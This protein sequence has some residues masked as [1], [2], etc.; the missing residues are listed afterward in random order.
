MRRAFL[1]FCILSAMS[2][3]VSAAPPEFVEAF[4]T[5][6]II[7]GEP[8]QTFI[9][10]SD[11]DPED[12][13]LIYMEPPPDDPGFKGYLTFEKFADTSWSFQ[14]TTFYDLI[15]GTDSIFAIRFY[16][17]DYTD[18][19]FTDASIT[20]INNNPRPSIVTFGDK[21]IVEGVTFID[22]VSATDPDGSIPTLS[23]STLPANSDF[24]LDTLVDTALGIF[25]FT[26]DNTQYGD[27]A[28][29]Y[30]IT[31]NASDEDS[32]AANQVTITVTGPNEAPTI[33]ELGPQTITEG[34]LLSLPILAIDPNE[35]RLELY[36][37]EISQWPQMTFVDS[38]AVSD[39]KWGVGVLEFT[40][41][42]LWSDSSSITVTIF[43][44]DGAFVA[45]QEVSITVDDA[46][47]QDPVFDPFPDTTFEEGGGTLEITV[48]ASDPEQNRLSLLML[49][50]L[51]NSSFTIDT[52]V[53]QG[54]VGLYSF[55]PGFDQGGSYEIDFVAIDDSLASD[56]ITL[57]LEIV[58]VDGPP[59]LFVRP[60]GAQSINEGQRLRIEWEAYDDFETGLEV[61]IFP[62]PDSSIF[63]GSLANIDLTPEAGVNDSGYM[64]FAPD[65]NFLQGSNSA[66]F[67]IEFSASDAY[68]TVTQSK[69]ITVYDVAQDD[70]DPGEADTVNLVNAVWDDSIPGFKFVSR[71]WNDSAVAA[72]MTGYRWFDS[73]FQCEKIEF[74]DYIL[75]SAAYTRT[76]IYND[77]LTFLATFIF[78]DSL[79]LPPGT[80]DH[81]TAY[82]KYYPDPE[83][84]SDIFPFLYDTASVGSNG[85]YFFDK[86]IR[87]KSQD[88][89]TEKDLLFAEKSPYTYKPLIKFGEVR[90]PGNRVRMEIYDL[91]RKVSLGRGDMLFARD[92]AD[93]QKQYE[94]RLK[95]ENETRLENISLDLQVFTES[96]TISWNYSDP[97]AEVIPSSRMAPDNQVWPVT[98]GLQL[99]GTG[100]DGLG[101]DS[102]RLTGAA[103]SGNGGLPR[104]LLEYMIKIPFTMNEVLDDS[105]RVY[106][107]RGGS[108]APGTWLFTDSSG[109]VIEPLFD[110]GLDLGV[111][112][113]SEI[114]TDRVKISIFDRDENEAIEEGDTLYARYS[115]FSL[116]HY[117]LRL[118]IENR[119]QLEN[120]SL[121]FL[122]SA[123][124]G[125]VFWAYDDPV[126]IADT[127]GRSWPDTLVWPTS[128]GWHFTTAS[129]DGQASDTFSFY[130]EAGPDSTGLPPGPLERVIT[131]PFTIN[132]VTGNKA[133]LCF[134]T[135]GSNWSFTD[136]TGQVMTPV[137]RGGLCLP[138]AYSPEVTTDRVKMEI[139]DI[140]QDLVLTTDSVLYVQDMEE[141]PKQ[142]QIR[143]ALENKKNLSQIGLD[144]L[145]G[146]PGLDVTWSYGDPFLVIDESSRLF[147]DTT[148]WSST[149]G[150]QYESFSLDGTGTDSLRLYGTESA[151]ETG[152]APGAYQ[153]MIGIPFAIQSV[154]GPDATLC[155][156]T[157]AAGVPGRWLFVDTAG[158]ESNPVFE[159]GGCFRVAFNPVTDIDGNEIPRPLT[160]SLDQNYP[161]PFNPS[162]VIGFTL[163]RR[164]HVKIR[165]F[166]ILG[167]AVKTLTDKVYDPGQHSLQWDGQNSRAEAVATGVYFYNIEAEGFTDTKK[168]LLLK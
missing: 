145:I 18:T 5:A 7:E 68:T 70:N 119:Y 120:L 106:F 11:P 42:F 157:G 85:E 105:A 48:S 20:V 139:V 15:S 122:M 9:T 135:A 77:S 76:Y 56:S 19:I 65:Y 10:I 75:D 101:Y 27:S 123:P 110:G 30:T 96:E 165:V 153:N 53:Q 64:E 8:F 83:D 87:A 111:A 17:T 62:P 140:G 115:N 88:K 102:L 130:G 4:D 113:N 103:E 13:F 142:Y 24:T 25:S 69:T 137:F 55:T 160:Y 126:Y 155:F 138:V 43:A 141:N 14:F 134:D 26:P 162:T 163:P 144:L 16:A 47:N 74:G 147:P 150:L 131:I 93:S 28:Q 154:T 152:L 133:F 71:I 1:F 95:L 104:G 159:G 54:G 92:T 59:N 121:D 136:T 40:P 50:T 58:E 37:S 86:R 22:S 94:L 63:K 82:F 2:L 112:H 146:A 98:S 51:P 100:I 60:G 125:G 73:R 99:T 132:D 164:S 67:N 61:E 91:D 156:D 80:H 108:Q 52:T 161:N 167:Q 117:E 78:Y 90:R 38:G 149:N 21:R 49:D 3:P 23:T 33:G 44:D 45:S 12:S 168:M 57:Y 151:G 129:L 39:D 6:T 97:V 46:G 127:T 143:L 148:V 116:K 124:D 72:A 89:A 166:N 81:F 158:S 31:F 29:D 32:T 118:E 79:F 36:T 107:D 128:N 109:Q 84:T 41:D 34:E 114:S 66:V 35:A